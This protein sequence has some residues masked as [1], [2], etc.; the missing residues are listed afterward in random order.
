[1]D[2]ASERSAMATSQRSAVNRQITVRNAQIP[3]HNGK[4]AVENVHPVMADGNEP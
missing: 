4:L 1:M 2:V 3:F